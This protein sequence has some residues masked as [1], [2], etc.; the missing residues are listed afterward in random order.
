MGG[1][2]DKTF[3]KMLVFCVIYFTFWLTAD[4][5]YKTKRSLL[6]E[7]VCFCWHAV[8]KALQFVFPSVLVLLHMYYI[9]WMEFFSFFI[10]AQFF[11]INIM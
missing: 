9:R 4:K 3:I 8:L 5:R 6:A 7:L 11:F 2:G 10:H 1:G